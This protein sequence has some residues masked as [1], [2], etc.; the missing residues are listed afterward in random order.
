MIF[1]INAVLVD[2]DLQNLELLKYSLEKYCPLINIVGQANTADAAVKMV[3]ELAPELIFMDIQLHYKNTFEI[4]DT[5]D[6]TKTE[7]IFV[8]AY[9]HYALKAFQYNAIAYLLKP[10]SVENLI[11][12]TNKVALKL[13]E[14]E[15]LNQLVQKEQNQAIIDTAIPA[16]HSP[17]LTISSLNN[18][19]ILKKADILFCKSEGR[20]TIFF[21]K[22]NIQH[23]SSKNLGA[24]DL[25]LNG[26]CFS[27]I[28]HSYIVNINHIL[29]INK[30]QGYY[31]EMISGALIPISRRKKNNLKTLLN[32]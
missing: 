23:V 4:L 13:E 22:D 32:I 19:L 29:T 1:R 16:N 6:C 17:Y 28:H 18:I 14:K 21:L 24:Y 26:D 5:I 9:S 7:I 20:Y 8:T 25:V 15:K 2:D 10:I 30:K 12:A 27:R 11:L 31:C 3:G